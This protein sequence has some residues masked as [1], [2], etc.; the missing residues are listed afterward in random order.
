MLEVVGICL[1]CTIASMASKNVSV[2]SGELR[3][4][5]FKIR[6]CNWMVIKMM[7]ERYWLED[8]DKKIW[9]DLSGLWNLID[10]YQMMR[11]WL[12]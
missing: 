5:W 6:R 9:S 1:T 7:G 3:S 2:K 4:L 8:V 12:Y 10:P 11:L